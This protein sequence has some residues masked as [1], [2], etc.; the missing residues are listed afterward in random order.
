M[1]PYAQFIQK[2]LL[3]IIGIMLL[4]SL[5]HGETILDILSPGLNEGG[6]QGENCGDWID[7]QYT[8]FQENNIWKVRVC[9]ALVRSKVDSTPE[10]RLKN[11]VGGI[12]YTECLPAFPASIINAKQ[13]EYFR[14]TLRKQM[15][16]L[17]CVKTDQNQIAI[18]Q[19]DNGCI[20]D[21]FQD[22]CAGNSRTLEATCPSGGFNWLNPIED[23]EGTGTDSRFQKEKI[24]RCE[25]DRCEGPK[26]YNNND[27]ICTDNTDGTTTCSEIRRCV[28]QSNS[29]D[30]GNG[31]YEWYCSFSSPGAVQRKFYYCMKKY[32]GPDPQDHAAYYPQS[33]D[34]ARASCPELACPDTGFGPSC[35]N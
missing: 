18:T 30:P 7:T 28:A 2:M 17:S 6:F 13:L 1:M 11:A 29:Q 16:G 33:C 5:A 21:A 23:D 8:L 26:C 15:P 35:G 22:V 27:N 31:Y 24:C 10:L 9:Q 3:I 14:T 25:N 19:N 4:S 20:V 34:A 32:T 12:R